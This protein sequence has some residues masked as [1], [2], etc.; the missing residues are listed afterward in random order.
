[1][2]EAV[3]ASAS[4]QFFTL[5]SFGCVMSAPVL[6]EGAA[7]VAA[8]HP[9][10]RTGTGKGCPKKDYFAESFHRSASSSL[11]KGPVSMPGL[12]KTGARPCREP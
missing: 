7:V 1:M 10:G 5:F 3:D 4:T 2:K 12:S 6:L 9:Q 11:G 8:G